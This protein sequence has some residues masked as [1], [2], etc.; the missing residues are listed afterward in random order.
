MQEILNEVAE[1][2]EFKEIII[3]FKKG[4]GAWIERAPIRIFNKDPYYDV[5]LIRFFSD[6]NTIDVAED[7]SIG[8]QLKVG[9][10][11][12]AADNILIWGTVVEE[13][14]NNGNEELEARIAALEL[15]LFGRLTDLS[16][17]TLLG[18]NSGTGVVEQIA[19]ATFAQPSDIVTATNAL[20]AGAPPNLN[21]LDKLAAAMGDD[22]TFAITLAAALGNKVNISGDQV[23]SGIIK[24]IGTYVGLQSVAPG[25]WLDETDGTRGAYIVCNGGSLSVQSRGTNFGAFVANLGSV[26]LTSG[27]VTLNGGIN[28]TSLP[29]S[30]TGLAAGS[31]WR[32]GTTLRIV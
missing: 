12:T 29:T 5:N 20:I 22:A 19:Q 24:F 6:A 16:P 1:N 14:K 13:K 17:N 8:I 2:T 3:Y 31:I 9:N 25:F 23:I 32:D 7:L 18:R 27:A 26:N 15:A 28:L 11:L 4:D 30:T 21:T 10:V